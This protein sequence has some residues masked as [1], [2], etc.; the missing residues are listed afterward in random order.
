MFH[1]SEMIPKQTVGRHRAF[2]YKS[3]SETHESRVMMYELLNFSLETRR[4]T[5]LP[6]Y[7]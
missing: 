2:Y 5:Y 3:P 1:H 4:N 7:T 6:N